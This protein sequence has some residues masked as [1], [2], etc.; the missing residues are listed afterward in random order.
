VGTLYNGV[1]SASEEEINTGKMNGEE[2]EERNAKNG[3]RN[4][5]KRGGE[6]K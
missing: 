6:R 2:I 5:G 1:L 3:E 4:E